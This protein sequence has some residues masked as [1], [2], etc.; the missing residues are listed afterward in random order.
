MHA[1]IFGVK[2]PPATAL[3]FDLRELTRWFVPAFGC[4]LLVLATLSDHMG[5]PSL[6]RAAH[7]LLPPL[8]SEGG[9]TAL[10]DAIG[11]SGINTVPATK[12]ERSFEARP[13]T[14]PIGTVSAFLISYTNKL[15]Q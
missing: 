15:I 10:P 13:A 9:T 1:R 12:F 2:T 14:N 8:G 11:H 7:L 6:H 3:A 4:F 5:N